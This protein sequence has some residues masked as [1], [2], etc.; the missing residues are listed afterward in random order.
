MG[1]IILSGVV[2]NN[3]IVMIDYMNHLRRK[4]VSPLEAIVEGAT[5]RLR[6]VLITTFTTVAGMLPMAL[7]QTQG[8]ELRSPM[9]VAVAGGLLFAT[10]LTLF[11]IPVAY[12]IAGRVKMKGV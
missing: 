11:V 7:S 4:G 9:A 5:I 3:G 2:V 10:F 1:M 8:S 6:P 12:S